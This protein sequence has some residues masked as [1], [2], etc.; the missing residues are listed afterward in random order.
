MNKEK[1]I[2]KIEKS[3]IDNRPSPIS[4]VSFLNGGSNLTTNDNIATNIITNIIRN[5]N[6]ETKS[7]TRK[8]ILTND[9]QN[10][11]LFKNN[12][13]EETYLINEED[14]KNIENQIN[15]EIESRCQSEKGLSNLEEMYCSCD[16]CKRKY[17][18][19]DEE[20]YRL[21][22]HTVC[23]RHLKLNIKVQEYINTYRSKNV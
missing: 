5:L 2:K 3:N 4:I 19:I 14:K 10:G 17:F 23:S 12:D 15:N 6:L 9:I 20:A 1:S 22:F 16:N 13:N 11:T 18:D 8:N 21:S 7:T